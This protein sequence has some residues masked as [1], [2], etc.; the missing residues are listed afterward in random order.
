M[1]GQADLGFTAAMG[2]STGQR[3]VV[4]V[5]IGFAIPLIGWAL[6]GEKGPDTLP[7]ALL[8]GAVICVVVFVLQTM[9]KGA[10]SQA[11]E[12]G[13]DLRERRERAGTTD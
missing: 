13:R 5:V 8:Q 9:R 4:A 12:A 10:R 1:A 11:F 3:A 6:P 7:G 2:M